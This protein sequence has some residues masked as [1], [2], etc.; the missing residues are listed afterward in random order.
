MALEPEIAKL[1]NNFIAAGRP[2]AREQSFEERRASYVAGTELAGDIETR[3]NIEDKIAGNI[4]LRIF[5]PLNRRKSLPAIIYY[6]G[7]CF[8]SGGFLTHERQLRQLAFLSGSVVIA[9]QY[10]LAPE[11]TYPAAHDDA[12]HAAN[13]VWRHARASGVD[14]NHITLMGDSAGGH[15]ALITALRLRNAGLWLPGQLILIYPMLD[16]TASCESYKLNGSDYVLTRETFLSG[17]EAYFPGM[18]FEHPEVSPLFRDDFRGLPPVHIITAE[19]DP[20]RDEGEALFSR[21]IQ[22]GVNCTA[23]RYLGVIHGFFQLGGI[24][25]TAHNLMRDICALVNKKNIY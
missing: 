8:V 7:G 10:R 6:H 11:H 2:S 1:V 21:M 4:Q 23:Q 14:R 3:V 13:I 24:S 19:Y 12:E 9:V 18:D 15:L 5:S 25:Q 22:Q 16:A 20:L 17:F